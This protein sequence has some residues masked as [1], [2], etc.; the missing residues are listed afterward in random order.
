MVAPISMSSG[1]I[2]R[3]AHRDK[4][5][6]FS[7]ASNWVACGSVS[8]V[9][10]CPT[11]SD[12]SQLLISNG[13]VKDLLL[14]LD[15]CCRHGVERQKQENSKQTVYAENLPSLYMGEW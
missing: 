10:L 13:M 5:K 14:A 9:C 3:V 15:I 2:V 8:I 1:Q 7:V 6:Y 12:C 4:R 11:V